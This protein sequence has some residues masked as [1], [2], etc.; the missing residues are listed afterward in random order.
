MNSNQNNL[1]SVCC[2][3]YNHG[4]YLKETIESICNIGYQNIEIIVVD[5]GSQDSSVQQLQ[6]L[7]DQIPY[8]LEILA[9]E[10]T[11]NIGKNFNNALKK[12]TGDLVTFIAL[13]DVFRSSVVLS[14]IKE[15]NAHPELAFIASAKTISINDQGLLNRKHPPELALYR[16][17]N[18]TVADCLELEYR[19]FGAFYI[20]G[21]MIR[22]E[23]VDAVGGFDEDMTGDDI[24]LRTKIFRYM[25][26]N[27]QWHFKVIKENNV[28]YRLH[29]NNVHK[30]IPR[31]IKIVTEYL[32]RYWQ[33][34]P[35]PAM[36]ILWVSHLIRN[37]LFKDYI[38]IF[39]LNKRATNLLKEAKIQQLIKQSIK[40]EDSFFR[41]FIFSRQKLNNGRR[42]VILFGFIR[43]SYLKDKYKFS[44]E[45]MIHY[46]EY[47]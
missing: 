31:Q 21:S 36:L 7:K 29:E 1:V 41:R 15:M 19:E 11:G 14:E 39:T 13:D 17:E 25:L 10:N 18:P 6:Q 33:D 42:Q 28:F 34:R 8:K 24:V 46:L 47:K 26:E 45:K 30:N 2:L 44:K 20:Q 12:A 16:M 27:P 40:K 22:K 32:D 37:Y 5:D 43:F 9:Q 23:V 3:G 35:N 38:H 4:E